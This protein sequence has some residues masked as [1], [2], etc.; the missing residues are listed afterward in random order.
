MTYA[1]AREQLFKYLPTVGWQVHTTNMRTYRRLKVA[2]ARN[3]N[4]TTFWFR[5]QA[6]HQGSDQNTA[7]SL[8]IDLRNMTAEQ[9]DLRYRDE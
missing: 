6:V 8:F 9:F 3:P 4:G 1:Q 5:T 7:H 2:Y